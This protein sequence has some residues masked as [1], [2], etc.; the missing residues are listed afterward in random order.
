MRYTIH[1]IRDG[2]SYNVR[3]RIRINV[4]N[5]ILTLYAR[6]GSVFVSATTW[7]STTYSCLK[8]GTSFRLFFFSLHE[9]T[10]KKGHLSFLRPTARGGAILLH[11]LRATTLCIQCVFYFKFFFERKPEIWQTSAS[12]LYTVTSCCYYETFFRHAHYTYRS[13]EQPL[14]RV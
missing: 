14:S 6:E 3:I 4:K 12:L 7:S 5:V 13:A 1:I 11:V 10:R 8:T 2:D 9:C